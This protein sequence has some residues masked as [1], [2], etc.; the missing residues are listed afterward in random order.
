MDLFTETLTAFE[1]Q[2]FS[3]HEK[4]LQIDDDEAVRKSSPEKW[5]IKEII[6]HLIDSASNNHQRFVRAQFSDDLV[7]PGYQQDDWI[8]VQNYQNESWKN[9]IELWKSFNLHILHVMKTANE[10]KRKQIRLKHNLHQLA[11]KTVPENEPATLEY[12]MLDYIGHFN[13]HLNQVAGSKK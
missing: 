12:F 13:H 9:L 7:F 10:S 11:W 2:I 6:G 3:W 5:S 8:S 1:N 4:L